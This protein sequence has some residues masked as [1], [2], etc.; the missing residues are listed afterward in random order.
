GGGMSLNAAGISV[1]NVD[2]LNVTV[3]GNTAGN[4]FS[5]S[6]GGIAFNLAGGIAKIVQSRIIGNF[7]AKIDTQ[8]GGPSRGGG[9]YAVNS[10]LLLENVLITGNDGERGHAL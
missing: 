4:E 7:A 8:S 3:Q 6:G 1:L 10:N 9:I 2:M 5:S